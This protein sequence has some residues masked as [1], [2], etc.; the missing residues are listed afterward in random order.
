MEEGKI[1]SDEFGMSFEV[2]QETTELSG[3]DCVETNAMAVHKI[4]KILRSSLGPHGMDK[5]IVDCDGQITMTNDGATIVK[6]YIANNR[7]C[8]MDLL[9]QLTAAQDSEVGDGT[10]SIVLFANALLREA[11]ILLKKGIHQIK[12]IE[13]YNLALREVIEIVKKN[14]S[15]RLEDEISKKREKCL[16]AVETALSSKIAW[17]YKN[18][19]NVCVD[20]LYSVMDEERRDIDLENINVKIL[21]G[22]NFEGISL[23]R[24]IS[25]EKPVV[26]E[27]ALIEKLKENKKLKICLLACPFEPPKLKTKSKLIVSTAEE[28]TKLSDYE[29]ETFRLMIRKVKDSGADLVL[30]QW[31]FDDEA[32][33]MLMEEKLPAVRWVGGHE[34]G[35][36]AALTNAQIV[37]RFEFLTEKCLG[38]GFVEL[39][40][41]GTDSTNFIN[42][43]KTLEKDTKMEASK[44]ATILVKS[45]NMFVGQEI[46]RSI[47]D[48]LNAA[49]NVL[50]TDYIVFGGG[51]LEINLYKK[52]MGNLSSGKLKENLENT[53]FGS[54]S[55]EI[56]CFKSF[57]SALL[58]IPLV[59]A[60][61]A[62]HDA[63]YVEEIL[64]AVKLDKIQHIGVGDG[65]NVDMQLENVFESFES[66]KRQYTMAIDFVCSLLKVQEVIYK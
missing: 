2:K 28:Y 21:K 56:L 54:C 32:T 49:R 51:S 29:K 48:A 26:G 17:K 65:V 16:K 4:A 20:A 52:I 44:V 36:I 47:T 57:A 18:I 23:V 41:F 1:I 43:T 13:G 50:F 15:I 10:T 39:N 55:E 27:E 42:I 30:C 19:Q 9:Q 40:N 34:L 22:G 33:S 7:G 24:G 3:I 5:I 8:V 58:E 31:G 6:E 63:K 35:Q 64:A 60:E 12:I 46:E 37:S 25:L 66:K 38:E 61:N 59:L 45:S 11:M 14:F 53:G 62:G